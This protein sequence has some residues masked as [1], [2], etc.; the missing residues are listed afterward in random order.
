MSYPLDDELLA[1]RRSR[2]LGP[3]P[4]TLL[5]R[6]KAPGLVLDSVSLDWALAKAKFENDYTQKR[7]LSQNPVDLYLSGYN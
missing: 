4:R 5:G 6:P 3:A 2:L 7:G 1:S